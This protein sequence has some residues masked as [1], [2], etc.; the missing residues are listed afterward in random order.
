MRTKKEIYYKYWS[1]RDQQTHYNT[2]DAIEDAMEE[3]AKEYYKGQLKKL[4]ERISLK[5]R[6]AWDKNDYT[7]SDGKSI[8]LWI[9]H[10][11][12]DESNKI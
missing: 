2:N 8:E 11:I 1:E 4:S 7:F 3:Y 5:F 6:K 10:T 9:K 12:E